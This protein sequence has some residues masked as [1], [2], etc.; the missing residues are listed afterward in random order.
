[1]GS[2]FW[3]ALGKVLGTQDRS[4]LRLAS[5]CC[6]LRLNLIKKIFNTYILTHTHTSMHLT[7]NHGIFIPK[8][9][10]YQ[11][12]AKETQTQTHLRTLTCE[13]WS[14]IKQSSHPSMTTSISSW[15][16]GN[17]WVQHHTNMFITKDVCSCQNMT[18]LY[19][20]CSTSAP[21]ASWMGM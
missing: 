13:T 11:P 14:Y 7:Y 8:Q 18:Y 6:V 5:H 9:H 15:N 19:L 20:P 17:R 3:Y 21:M 16:H 2:E 10:I 1:M 12:K 4:T